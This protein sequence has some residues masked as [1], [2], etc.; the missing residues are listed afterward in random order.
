[1]TVAINPAKVRTMDM[2]LEIVVIPVADVERAKQF[3]AG[4]SWRLDA[5]FVFPD[6]FRVIQFTPPGSDASVIFG[7]NVTE[8]APGSA[9]GLYLVVSDIEAARQELLNSGVKVSEVFHGG[10]NVHAGIDEP[11]LFGSVRVSGPGSGSAQLLL[12]GVVQ[13]SRWQRLDAPGDHQSVAWA[14]G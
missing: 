13:R 12:A 3:Y 6:G 9:K 7:T 2:K 11:H 8:A 10:D 4:L 5:D 1:M 14:C